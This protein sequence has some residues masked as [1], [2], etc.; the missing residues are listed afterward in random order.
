MHNVE[1][2][3]DAYVSE[4]RELFEHFLAATDMMRSKQTVS[5]AEALTVAAEA[6]AHSFHIFVKYRSLPQSV[7]NGERIAGIRDMV[8]AMQQKLIAEYA[9][10]HELS[11]DKAYVDFRKATELAMLNACKVIS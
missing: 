6:S 8:V 3:V 11:L 7:W 2:K 10:R 4:C 1:Q 9:N 5:D